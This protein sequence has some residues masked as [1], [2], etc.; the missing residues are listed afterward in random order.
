MLKA[1]DQGGF[2]SSYQMEPNAVKSGQDLVERWL[3]IWQEHD[4]ISVENLIVSKDAQALKYLKK[5]SFAIKVF[6]I[7]FV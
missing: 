2:I 7:L 3:T 1:N 6:L 5:V 4:I